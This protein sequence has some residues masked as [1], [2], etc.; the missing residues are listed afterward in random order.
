M[1]RPTFKECMQKAWDRFVFM[2]SV[3]FA[4]TLFCVANY[5]G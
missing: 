5:K 3:L 1:N 2:S 4:V